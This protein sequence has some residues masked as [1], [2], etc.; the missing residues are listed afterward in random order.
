LKDTDVPHQTHMHDLV[1]NTWYDSF[2]DLQK[3]VKAALGN[4]SFTLDIWTNSNCK[5]YLAMTGHW[6]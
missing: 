2:V 3:Q 1:I 5:S 4:V 6:I